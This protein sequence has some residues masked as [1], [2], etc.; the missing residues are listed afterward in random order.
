VQGEVIAILPTEISGLSAYAQSGEIPQKV[1]DA[2]A[3]AI[4]LKQ[5]LADTERQIAER[6]QQI[7]ENAAEQGRVRENLRTLTQQQSQPYQRQLAK[8]ND[9]ESQI[10][11]LQSE[12][13]E[14]IKKRDTQRKDLEDHLATLDVG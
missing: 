12:R 4:Q 13:D 7:S 14:L 8:L 9:I 6:V 1:R 3:Q 2:L 11:K 5:A 10:E